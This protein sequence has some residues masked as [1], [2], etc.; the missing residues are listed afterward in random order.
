MNTSILNSNNKIIYIL[1]GSL[2][3]KFLILSVLGSQP[4]LDGQWYINIASKIWESGFLFPNNEL[5]DAP[6]TPY[7]YALFY[8]L[9]K[10]IGM[11]A[12]AIGNIIIST[13]SIYIFYKIS[14]VIFENIKIANLVALISCLYPF[15]NFYAISIL[16]ESAYIFFLYLSFFC[17]IKYFK[18]L[19]LKYLIFFTVFFALDTLIRFTNL[20]MYVFFLL[21][22]IYITKD[23]QNYICIT[24]SILISCFF[25]ILVMSIWWIRNYNVFNEFV[26]TS[27]GE[28]GK[29]FFIGNNAFNKTGGGIGGVDVKYEDLIRFK[30]IK[31][32]R[33][34]DKAMWNEGIKWIKDNPKD[35]IVLEF[36]KIVRFFSPIFFADKFNKWY[37]NIISL[38]S[39]GVIFLFFIFSLFKLKNYFWLY[40]PMFLYLVLLTGVHLVFIASIRYRIPIEPFMIILAS[41]IILKL[42][43]KYEKTN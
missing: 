34:R 4:L 42:Y 30:E 13:C 7:F 41:P 2:V 15:F 3:I 38:L 26:P 6:G 35:W 8:P 16:S 31:D 21:L 27:V 17:L 19:Q 23:K 33:K 28:S 36:K 14:F 10:L 5:R 22:T 43:E 9:Y 1:L 29:V 39:Y 18:T 40:S 20:P 32:L 12:Y 24:K 11:N 25:F 37:Y